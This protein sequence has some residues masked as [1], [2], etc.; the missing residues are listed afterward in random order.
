M[1]LCLQNYNVT[2]KYWPGNEMLVAD[3]VSQYVPLKAPEIPLDITISHVHIILDRKTEFQTLIQDDLLLCSLTEMIIAGWPKDINDIPH[4][5]SP[6]HGHRNILTVEDGL[7]LWGEALIILLSE[8][9]KILQAIHGHMGI[10]KCQKR[11]RHSVYWPRINSDIKCLVESCPICQ[12][13]QPQEPWQLLQP[14]SA[15]EHPW[16]LLGTEYSHFDGSKYLVITD[17]YSKMPI[18][19]RIPASQCNGSKTISVLKELFAEHCIPE[20]LPTDNGPQ[21][22]NALFTEFATDWKFD[23]NNILLGILEAMVKLKQLWRLSKD[24]SLMPSALVKT[25]T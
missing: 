16:Q 7:I 4:A 21:F 24:C 3:A 14:T 15:L 2:L 10:S 17:Y 19:R 13:H 23:H 9:E 8:R 6:Y 11:A 12:C 22:A 20:V 1:L 25:H 18:V 5:L